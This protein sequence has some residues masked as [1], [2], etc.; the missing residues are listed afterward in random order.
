M[1]YYESK[2]HTKQNLVYKYRNRH[3]RKMSYNAY[4]GKKLLPYK[5]QSRCYINKTK[6][7]LMIIFKDLTQLATSKKDSTFYSTQGHF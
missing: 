3:Y 2:T 1:D 4:F 5:M 7:R 6:E